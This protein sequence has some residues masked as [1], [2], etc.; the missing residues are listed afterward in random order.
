[1]VTDLMQTHLAATSNR[2]NEVMKALATISTIVLPMTLVAGIYGM[3]F[4]HM[5]EIHWPWGYPAALA[6]MLLVPSG[7]A[8][9]GRE[10]RIGHWLRQVCSLEGIGICPETAVCFDCLEQ[11]RQSGKVKPD[12]RVVVFNTGAVQKYPEAVPLTLPR[13][14]KAQPLDERILQ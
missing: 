1:M 12:E 3:N 4:E 14:D 8:L 2:L 13:L 6:V 7:L 9:A 11:L 5:P 10:E